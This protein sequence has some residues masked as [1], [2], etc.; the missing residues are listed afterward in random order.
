ML[1][2]TEL[3][4]HFGPIAAVNNIS[5]E[6]KKGDVLG[7]L[8][9]NGAGKTT[10]MRMIT[11]FLR[12]NGG[13]AVIDGYDI[14]HQSVEARRRIGYLPENAPVYRDTTVFNFLNFI[15]EIRGYRGRERR[16]RVDRIMETCKLENVRHQC[17]DTLSKGYKQRVCFAQ[18]ILH[19]P[20]LL[21]MDEPTDG[22]DPNQKNIV[23]R[24]IL[25]MA[26]TKAV[27]IS[28]H[29]LEEVDA[30]CNRTIVISNGRI[31]AEGS[32]EELK[33]RSP[34]HGA[35]KLQLAQGSD[36]VKN[37]LKALPA[38]A[39]VE[40]TPGHRYIV[41]PRRPDVLLRQIMDLARRGGWNL[42]S[43]EL[44]EGRL[45]DTFRLLTKA[46]GKTS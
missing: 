13:T 37:E 31:A 38:A 45:D 22:L 43:I 46:E 7:F 4:K 2:V 34:M 5:F 35:V 20:P 42:T 1:T 21:I 28:T 29:I 17:V 8:G 19:D 6:L 18:A 39:R 40:T 26:Q 9:P 3:Q 11:G 12:P 27:I 32:P 36:D 30:V 41:Y 33:R 24:M 23:R 10:T 25:G 16:R 44:S 15:A 14:R